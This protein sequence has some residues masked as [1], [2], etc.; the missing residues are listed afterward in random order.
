MGKKITFGHLLPFFPPFLGNTVIC[1]LPPVQVDVFT[2]KAIDLGELKKLRIR[3]DNS[4]ASPSWFLERV[5]IVDLKESTTWAACRTL[6]VWSEKGAR[7]QEPA[8]PQE[9]RGDAEGHRRSSPPTH[10]HPLGALWWLCH[11][12]ECGVV[13]RYLRCC[14]L[15]SQHLCSLG[16]SSVWNATSAFLCFS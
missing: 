9:G 10:R 1:L 6:F 2:I 12:T 11:Y 8:E 5:E 16:T 15:L 14:V 4:G 7:S 13:L 3:H